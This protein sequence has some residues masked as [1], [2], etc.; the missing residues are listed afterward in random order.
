MFKWGR[1]L[2]QNYFLVEFFES[3]LSTL[4]KFSLNQ[5]KIIDY[6]KMILNKGLPQ[7]GLG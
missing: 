3:K 4:V 5:F 6:L 7:P 2:T 1:F